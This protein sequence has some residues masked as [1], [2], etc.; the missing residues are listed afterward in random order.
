[1]YLVPRLVEQKNREDN[2]KDDNK[3]GIADVDQ[4]S[5]LNTITVT[6][7]CRLAAIVVSCFEGGKEAGACLQ[8]ST[9]TDATP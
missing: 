7:I 6:E 9:C 8:S 4:V 1:M 5:R 2:Q 3:D